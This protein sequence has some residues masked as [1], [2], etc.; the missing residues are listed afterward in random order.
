M[1]RLQLYIT[2]YIYFP[3]D[4]PADFLYPCKKIEE[5]EQEYEFCIGGT[6]MPGTRGAGR[7]VEG[8]YG[9]LKKKGSETGLCVARM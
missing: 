4:F 2:I 1:N 3:T 8:L 9:I 7:L 6:D 5:S